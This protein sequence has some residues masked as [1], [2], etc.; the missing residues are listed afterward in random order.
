MSQNLQK[1]RGGTLEFQQLSFLVISTISQSIIKSAQK[2]KKNEKLPPDSKHSQLVI[3]MFKNIL[4]SVAN[5]QQR[6]IQPSTI[7][8]L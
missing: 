1:L 6:L 4:T 8:C 7:H 3:L 2:R 5:E